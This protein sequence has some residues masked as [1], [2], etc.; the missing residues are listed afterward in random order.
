MQLCGA[1]DECADGWCVL[2]NDVDGICYDERWHT[3]VSVPSNNPY[4]TV[5]DGMGGLAAVACGPSANV[6]QP[7][8]FIPK[9]EALLTTNYPAFCCESSYVKKQIESL[10]SVTVTRRPRVIVMAIARSLGG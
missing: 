9:H 5:C 2:L 8:C 7:N 6:A 1:N 10:P 4:A 3:C